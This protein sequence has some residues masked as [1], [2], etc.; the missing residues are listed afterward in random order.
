M[1]CNT[2]VCPPNPHSHQNIWRELTADRPPHGAQPCLTTYRYSSRST[3]TT[4]NPHNPLHNA[5]S[6]NSARHTPQ[7]SVCHVSYTH[8]SHSTIMPSIKPNKGTSL[9]VQWLRL[10]TSTAR[11]RVQFLVREVT[12]PQW[13]L[14]T[15]LTKHRQTPQCIDLPHNKRHTVH[16]LGSPCASS[17]Y[18][19]GLLHNRC[20]HSTMKTLNP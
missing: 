10:C 12:C 15:T 6:H 7:T 18:K 19:P 13:G 20:S 5:H 14:K 3:D 1:T 2:N 11:A 8:P 4:P 9:V 16:G 17:L